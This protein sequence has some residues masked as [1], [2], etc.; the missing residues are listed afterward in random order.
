MGLGK[1]VIGIAAAEELIESGKIR[2]CLIVCPASLKYQ[3]AQRIAQFTN[4]PAFRMKVRGDYIIIPDADCEI[5]DGTVAKRRLQY[6]YIFQNNPAYVIMGYD[7]VINDAQFVSKIKP[8]MVIIDEA[9]AIKTFKAKRTKQIKKMLKVPYRLA[10]TGTPIENRP[11]EL[12]SIMQWVDEK[13]LGRYDLFDK[14]YCK[15][16]HYGWVTGYKNLPVLR[17]RISVAMSRKSRLDPDVRPYLPEVDYSEDWTTA[18]SKPV[19]D[20]Y[21]I[22][23]QDI[24]QEM[25]N[26]DPR[27]IDINAIYSGSDENTAQGKIMAMFMCLEMLLDHPDLIILSAQNDA[28]YANYLWQEGYLDSIMESQKLDL[29]KNK[30]EEILQYPENKIVIFSFYRGMLDIIQ[31]EL[32]AKTVQYHGEMSPAEKTAAINT[33]ATDNDCRILLSSHAGAY[34][35]DLYMANYLINYDQPWSSGRADQINGRHVRVSSEFKN[36][37]VRD[38]LATD[39][40]DEWK[41]RK[42]T[43]KRKIAGSVLD[44]QGHDETGSVEIDGDS[45][46]DHL[47]WVV[48]SW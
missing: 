17:K 30:I 44:G 37:F 31:E 2:C 39:T 41:K 29:L 32:D 35:A 1:T 5:I 6:E 7:N 9:T 26:I 8:E 4:V 28:K 46:K 43:R 25:K 3:W 12:F 27:S 47:L 22:I 33:F 40:I 45:L 16:N 11:D 14:A 13:V 42:V 36:V 10:L 19:K 15:R 34:G 38:I 48:K 23:A 20:L 24:L 18:I 21:K